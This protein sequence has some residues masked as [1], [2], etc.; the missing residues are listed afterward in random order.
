MNEFQ[1]WFGDDGDNTHLLNYE[2]SKDS[3]VL[4][5]GGYRGDFAHDIHSK[6][7]CQVHIFEPISSFYDFIVDRFKEVEDVHVHNFGIADED[8]SVKISLNGDESSVF[9]EG[10][11]ME[12]ISLRGVS[13]VLKELSLDRIDLAKVNIEGGEYPL[14]SHLIE[15]KLIERISNIQIQFH[16]FADPDGM[17]RFAL[18]N[19]LK[20][21][22]NEKFNYEFV[23]EGWQLK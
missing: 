8:S 1:R 14:L 17:R 15:T 9:K 7:G 22:H 10:K 16:T 3:V 20:E 12:D 21:T 19:K 23:W 6:Y 2:L 11:I 13:D 4:D 5:I 18:R